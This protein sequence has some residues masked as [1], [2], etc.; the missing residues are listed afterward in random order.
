MSHKIALKKQAN[1]EIPLYQFSIIYWTTSQEANT[2]GYNVQRSFQEFLD[3]EKF[4][5]KEFN[6]QKY[7][8]LKGKL[9]EI[10][11]QISNKLNESQVIIKR[12]ES[13]WRFIQKLADTRNLW[14]RE[15]LDFFKIPVQS[16]PDFL[17]SRDQ[18]NNQNFEHMFKIISRK[19]SYLSEKELSDEESENQ[20]PRLSLQYSSQE[21]EL[22]DKSYYIIDDYYQNQVVVNGSNL[23][24]KSFLVKVLNWQKGSDFIEFVLQVEYLEGNGY[25]WN[26][27]RRYTDFLVLHEHLTPYFQKKKTDDVN[28]QIPAAPPRIKKEDVKGLYVRQI[29]LEKYLQKILSYGDNPHALM[30]F[31]EFGTDNS[32]VQGDGLGAFAMAAPLLNERTLLQV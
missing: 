12:R 11:T 9:P 26:I 8:N 25:K 24:G 6:P 13:L 21:V 18:V 1:T 17:R 15:V 5:Q 10:Q 16:H 31:I 27:L 4:L 22:L 29:Q 7:P 23:S 2:P 32:M 20:D 14:C 3:L 19:N 30:Q 28:F